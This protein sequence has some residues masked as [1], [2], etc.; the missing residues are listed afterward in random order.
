MQCRE[1]GKQSLSWPD[2]LQWPFLNPIEELQ[3]QGS[4]VDSRWRPRPISDRPLCML[5]CARSEVEA[6]SVFDHAPVVAVFVVSR[7]KNDTVFVERNR[8][9]VLFHCR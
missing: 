9:A 5:W 4:G 7:H 1:P 8:A 2:R 3:I 6:A